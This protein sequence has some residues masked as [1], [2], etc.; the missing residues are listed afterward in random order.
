[1]KKNLQSQHSIDIILY[2]KLQYLIPLTLIS[3]VNLKHPVF[4]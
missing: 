2:T 3:L 1:M 4:D